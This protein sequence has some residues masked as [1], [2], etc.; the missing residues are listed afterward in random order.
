MARAWA[1]VS[2]DAIAA[3]VERSAGPPVK[4]SRSTARAGALVH[5][6]GSIESIPL[7]AQ[8]AVK[9]PKTAPV[10]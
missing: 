8:V 9:R 10:T 5:A 1:D 6:N 2:L 4:T 7:N 3:N